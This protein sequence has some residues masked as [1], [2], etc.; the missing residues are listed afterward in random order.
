MQGTGRLATGGILAALGIWG[1]AG[2]SA[3]APGVETATVVAAGDSAAGEGEAPVVQLALLLDTSN[4]MDGLI[5][6]AKSQLWKVVNEFIT[7]RQDGKTPVAQVA[8]YEYGK[9]SLSA[10]GNWIRQIQPLSRDLDKISEELFKLTTNGGDEYCGAVIKK[11]VEELDWNPSQSVYKAIFIAGNEPFTQGSVPPHPACKEAIAKGIIVNTIHCGSEAEGVNGGWKQGALVADGKFL[12]IDQNQAVAHI[13]APQDVEITRLNT[14]LNGT[15]VPFG[16]DG[17]VWKENQLVQ[18][19]NAARFK[20]A[21]SET[22]RAVT[23]AS[24]NYWNGKWDLVDACKAKDFKWENLKPEHLPAELKG[25]TIAE[26]RAYVGEKTKERSAIQEKILALNSERNAYVAG[27]R[28]EA[29][30]A[31]TL[32]VAVTDAIREQASRKGIVWEGGK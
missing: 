27:K 7:A 12:I 9:S 23:K 1:V 2:I 28:K 3:Q 22:Q 5:E 4:S 32:D 25:K 19:A 8:L 21:G 6:Q 29:G 13:E 17:A 24:A 15:Y 30:E 11:A 14:E 18:D 31:Q 10:E 20:Q 26:C 16:P